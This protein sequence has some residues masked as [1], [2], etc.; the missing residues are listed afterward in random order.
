MAVV[1]VQTFTLTPDKYEAF[2][3]QVREAKK[4]LQRAGAMNIRV[5]AA[6]PAGGGTGS[7]AVSWEAADHATSGAVTDRFLADPEGL[8][9]ATSANARTFP[10]RASKARSG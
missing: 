3:E 2:R 7:I 4:V 10:Q 6:V 5:L 8:A 1:S 9:I